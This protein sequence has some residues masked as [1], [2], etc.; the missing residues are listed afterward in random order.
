MPIDTLFPYFPICRAK[1]LAC[2][3]HTRSEMLSN[4]H[5]APIQIYF[6]DI[7]H[8]DEWMYAEMGCL[9]RWYENRLPTNENG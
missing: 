6:R 7:Y 8:S 2:T 1:I 5:T 9:K 4:L 3:T